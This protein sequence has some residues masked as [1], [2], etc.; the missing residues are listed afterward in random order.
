MVVP[1]REEGYLNKSLF[2]AYIFGPGNKSLGTDSFKIFAFYL[3]IY[4]NFFYLFIVY[5][6]I[7][8]S[9]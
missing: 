9:Y 4:S 8:F 5:R 1:V 7:V 2:M 6:F 3:L